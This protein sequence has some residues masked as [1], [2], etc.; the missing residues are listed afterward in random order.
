MLHRALLCLCWCRGPA[1]SRATAL[2][3]LLPGHHQEA[4]IRRA[5]PGPGGIAAETGDVHRCPH[6]SECP[7][8]KELG[9]CEGVCL[10]LSEGF[11]LS[12]GCV[13]PV[14]LGKERSFPQA[15]NGWLLCG[16][17]YRQA[18]EA[19][20]EALALLCCFVLDHVRLGLSI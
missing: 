11:T 12:S 8:P 16:V 5:F 15:I 19:A 18:P 2:A 6:S 4:D 14:L 20:I 13:W 7:R 9:T 10:P 1:C 17:A 3:Q